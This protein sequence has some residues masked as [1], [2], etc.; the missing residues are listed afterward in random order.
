[1]TRSPKREELCKHQGDLH[2]AIAD[3]ESHRAQYMK[4]LD[5]G[6]RAAALVQQREA[7]LAAI[8]RAEAEVIAASESY[9]QT[10]EQAAER[11]RAEENLSAARR[12]VSAI[13]AHSRVLEEPVAEAGS[14]VAQFQ[15]ETPKFVDDVLREEADAALAALVAARAEVVRLEVVVRSISGALVSRRALRHAEKVNVAIN[16]ARWPDAQ[17]NPA[18]YLRLAEQ[19]ATDADAVAVLP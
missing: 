6:Q 15:A 19:L 12:A 8:D 16:T 10:E 11:R 18:P 7:A 3:V 9:E 14:I 4:V 2:Q 17:P 5:Q 1:M 13:Y